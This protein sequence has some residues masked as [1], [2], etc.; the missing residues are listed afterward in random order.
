MKRLNLGVL[1]ILLILGTIFPVEAAQRDIK[2]D[3]VEVNWI[4][5][6]SPKVNLNEVEDSLNKFALST[7]D[8]LWKSGAAPN[9]VR[10]TMGKILEN[11]ITLQRPLDC[12][13]IEFQTFV[14]DIRN[15]VYRNLGIPDTRDRSVVILVPANGCQWLGR[16]MIG[17]SSEFGLGLVLHNTADPFVISH[18][19]G[20]LLGLG[21]SNL[22]RCLSGVSDGPWGIDCGG[23]EYGGAVDLMSNVKRSGPLSIYHQWRLGIVDDNQIFTSL[24][25]DEVELNSVDSTNGLKGIFFT[26]EKSAYWIEFRRGN[27]EEDYQSG[28]VIYRTDPPPNEFVESPIQVNKQPVV[29]GQDLTSE[30][31][32]LNLDSF[33]YSQ[34]GKASG[35][36]TLQT[37]KTFLTYSGNIKVTAKPGNNENSVKVSIS[38]KK[39]VS[40]PP[41]PILIELGSSSIPELEVLGPG[42]EDKESEIV[43]F[44]AKYNGEKIERISTSNKGILQTYLDPFKSRKILRIRDLPE[45]TFNLQIR[46]INAWGLA[47]PWSDSKMFRIDRSIPI[48]GDSINIRNLS[49]KKIQ[50]SLLDFQDIGSGL[51]KTNLIND[52]GFAVQQDSST[53]SPAFFFGFNQKATW[54]FETFDCSENGIA[55]VLNIESKLTPV[56]EIRKFGNW[57]AFKSGELS[58]L[59]C[60]GKCSLFMTAKENSALIIG[61]GSPEVFIG[62]EL[63]TRIS[64]TESNIARIAANVSVKGKSK[65]MRVS[66]RDFTVFGLVQTKIKIVGERKIDN[67]AKPLDTTLDNVLQNR[68]SKFGFSK[69][70]FS[71]EW[72]IFPME[73]GTTLQDPTLDLC[74]AQYK[75]ESDREIRRQ[76]VAIK[77]QSPYIFVSSEV[78][79]YRTTAMA[80]NAL[81]E[82]QSNYR[83]CFQSNIGLESSGKVVDYTFFPLPFNEAKLVSENSR[84]IVR[85]QIGKGAAARQ[86][87]AFYQFKDEIFSGLYV[88]KASEAGFKDSEVVDWFDVAGVLAQRLE[89]KY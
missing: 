75:S 49:S 58:G 10:I 26:D 44:E 37:N 80:L 24:T 12:D 83:S 56:S 32:M 8:N 34:S 19:I 81:R 29:P 17:N 52:L 71:E 85:A 78:V 88:V 68:I 50:I 20:H 86:L 69:G 76:L 5:A 74:G 38:R 67:N 31:W 18:E 57:I 54:K 60:L 73:N 36:M 89:T 63:F 41:K 45:G 43:A 9:Q 14:R 48:T 84:V 79:K 39:D 11:P 42:F 46:T 61:G 30:V 59:K 53:G 35:S 82:L 1:S 2:L 21:H 55:G 72:T 25:N 22:L 13:E 16:A 23:I 15:A 27:R 51:C 3:L 70:D 62:G 33:R 64:N 4:G 65:S 66:G 28:L 87:L 7:W 6:Q 47:S 77:Q 40:A